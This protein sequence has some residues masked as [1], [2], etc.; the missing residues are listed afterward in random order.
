MGSACSTQK[1][2]KNVEE[3]EHASSNSGE[4]TCKEKAEI[5]LKQTSHEEN[6]VGSSGLVEE[7][8]SVSN[9]TEPSSSVNHDGIAIYSSEGSSAEE[10]KETNSTLPVQERST[11]M[12]EHSVEKQ[13]HSCTQSSCLLQTNN[14]KTNFQQ[15]PAQKNCHHRPSSI[16][17]ASSQENV[18]TDPHSDTCQGSSTGQFV[19]H[20]LTSIILPENDLMNN[21][22]YGLL[23][24]AMQTKAR[25]TVD[26]YERKYEMLSQLKQE[27]YEEVLELFKQ[28]QEDLRGDR[29][30][31]LQALEANINCINHCS[32][33]I[34][35]DRQI[36]MIAVQNDGDHLS[37]VENTE[38]A[39]DR[40]LVFLA[41][42]SNASSV[43]YADESLRNDKAF[44]LK[45]IRTCSGNAYDYLGENLLY[46]REVALAAVEMDGDA[47][48]VFSDVIRNDREIF[49]KAVKTA[50][51]SINDAGDDIKNDRTMFINDREIATLC[52]KRNSWSFNNVGDDLKND[53]EFVKDAIRYGCSLSG[54]NQEF[55]SDKEIVMM[56]IN[57]S[58]G[59]SIRYASDELKNDEEC[60]MAAI[61]NQS[62]AL[63]YI[64]DQFKSNKELVS[65]LLQENGYL[66]EELSD[67]LKADKELLFTAI[68]GSYSNALMHASPE[69]KA[70]REVIME[71]VR[72][73]GH[74]LAYCA[75]ELKN[76]FEIV[77]EAVKNGGSLEYA[78]S[79]LRDNAELCQAVLS[80]DTYQYFG[81]LMKKNRDL[82]IQAIDIYGC[83]YA[84]IDDSLK[85]DEELAWRA[86]T[87]D[88]SYGLNILDFDEK[89]QHDKKIMLELIKKNPYQFEQLW[90]PFKS[91]IEFITQAVNND[92]NTL[93]YVPMAFK[94]DRSLIKQAVIMGLS[95]SYLP[96]AF[97]QD[98]EIVK[99]Y[100]KRGS[101][102]FYHSLN[103][104]LKSDP[105]VIKGA[106][107]SGVSLSSIPHKFRKDR[108]VCLQ[109]LQHQPSNYK[110]LPQEYASDREFILQ[111]ASFSSSPLIHYAVEWNNDK[112]I[113]MECV[114]RNG[115]A[116]DYASDDLKQDR[117]V[118]ME[119][120]KRDPSVLQKLDDTLKRDKE[121]VS[122]A[123]IAS[124]Y[125]IKY[126]DSSLR[127]DKE[128]IMKLMQTS[129]PYISLLM[130]T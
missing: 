29:E 83:N 67:E 42:C 20:T 36:M 33:N 59:E 110:Y 81:P 128:F 41:C 102:H 80:S 87:S 24:G 119:A 125:Y 68:S 22:L 104:E 56:A 21:S 19:N 44:M 28:A 98:P 76:D 63:R 70:D 86:V 99:L 94:K 26:F 82:A 64:G 74:C 121:I 100:A 17:M 92:G 1:A 30:I 40:E 126:A 73:Q 69:L 9:R 58:G 34:L 31:V 90:K 101:L 108:S 93:R 122:I 39:K 3:P 47:F 114:K 55:T 52:I 18:M 95:Y 113:V 88:S 16:E 123:A 71:A 116:L 97:K 118:I 2:L 38:L 105:D 72:I 27:D 54:M 129:P 127:R 8:S 57:F 48:R 77:L 103:E 32:Q 53:R 124:P 35:C 15:V 115:Y 7:N 111:A 51:Q 6:V 65:D 37:L 96:L 12:K 23:R 109:A 66:F 117:E 45:I 78:S 120:L 46:D 85:Q 89:F 106:L 11:V 60:V 84:Y 14:E 43:R 91:D 62:S 25:T 130:K 13:F 107:L 49:M 112:E 10:R 4:E 5:P 79:D 75:T 61:Q 50:P